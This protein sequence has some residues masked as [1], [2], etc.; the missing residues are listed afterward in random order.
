MP[1]SIYFL[2][3]DISGINLP[4]NVTLV[5]L[6]LFPSIFFTSFVSFR[7]FV[8]KLIKLVC[9][10]CL[11]TLLVQSVMYFGDLDWL[12]SPAVFKIHAD[13]IVYAL[14]AMCIWTCFSLR[15]IYQ[16][17]VNY[18]PIHSFNSLHKK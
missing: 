18:F 1:K 2:F 5:E 17:T 14:V 7:S 11:H 3:R 15:I 13:S 10:F 8:L 9:H 16:F 4:Q 6:F 12:Y